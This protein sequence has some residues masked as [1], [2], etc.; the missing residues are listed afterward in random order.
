MSL[1]PFSDCPVN[2]PRRPWSKAI[3]PNWTLALLLLCGM[4]ISPANAQPQDLASDDPEVERQSFRLLPG[5]EVNLFAAEPML[6]NPIHM[7]WD[8]DGR[9]WVV[10]STTY[11]QVEPGEIPDDQIIVLED[12]DSDGKADKRTVFAGGLYVPT[13]LEL[14]DGGVYV[15][16]APDL[17]FLKDTDDDGKADVRR[18]VLSGFGTEDNHHSISAWRWG[19]GGWLYFQEGTFLHAQVETP[20]GLVRLENGGVYQF[21]PQTLELR[22]F[23]DYRASNP[24]GH[25]FDRWG[26]SILID[27]P[28]IFHLSPLTANSRA[29]LDFDELFRA[30]TKH[31]GGEFVSGRHLPEEFR[32]EIWTNAYKTH[33][34][35]RYRLTDADAGYAVRQLE[36]VL[37]SDDPHFRPVELK[38]GPDGAVYIADWYNLLIG[39]MQHEF[40]DPRRDKTHGRIWRITYRDRPLLKKPRLTDAP[41]PELL[42]HLKAPE[43]WTRHQVK[44]VISE[45]DPRTVAAALKQWVATLDADD[46][47]FEHHRLE[48]LWCYQTIDVMEPRLLADVLGSKDGRARAAAVRVIRY[49]HD[50]LQNP[51]GLLAQ[52]A[53]DEHPRV[54]MEAVLSLSYIPHAE[55]MKTALRVLDKPMD[56]F[57][58]HSL[59]LAVDGLERYWLPAFRA[60]DF[61]FENERH[62]TFALSNVRSTD[63]VEPLLSLLNSSTVDFKELD[64]VLDKL[65]DTANSHQLEPVW[66]RLTGITSG[67]LPPE[68]VAKILGL[69]ETAARTR[70]V[71][72]PGNLNRLLR[73]INR[74][75]PAVQIAAVR[76]AGAWRQRNT[77]ARIAALARSEASSPALRRAAVVALAEIGGSSNRDVLLGM[78]GDK[79]PPP[80]RYLGLIGLAVFN[81]D[82]AAEHAGPVLADDPGSADPA[83]VAAAF[84][85][86]KRGAEA[87]ARA[88]TQKAPHPEVAHRITQYLNEIGLQHPELTAALGSASGSDVLEK[89]LLAEDVQALVAD[90]GKYGDAARGERI[91]RRK[92]LACM[93]CHAINGAGPELGPDLASIGSSS[94]ADFLVDAVLR[95]SKAIKDMYHSV[96][97]IT[98][99]GR[100][101]NGILAYK[102][103]REV[104]LRDAARQGVA[105]TIPAAQVDEIVPSETSLMPNGL[106]RN[107]GSRQEFLDLV[108]FLSQLGRPGPY[109]VQ[110]K[111]MIRR[112]RVAYSTLAQTDPDSAPT[113]ESAWTPAYSE[114]NGELPASLLTIGGSD[115]VFARGEIEILQP[116]RIRLAVNANEGLS[117]SI[118]GNSVPLDG[119]T[120]DIEL[121]KG[122]HTITF[123]AD[124]ARRGNVGLSCE[125]QDVPG[126]TAQYQVVVG[127]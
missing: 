118:D 93:S 110:T 97:V 49:W 85:E 99:E 88:L 117:L 40:R 2:S 107:L 106:A 113:E 89:Q 115:L 24:W 82:V 48:A 72:P 67:G 125:L 74:R 90:I 79:Q 1:V 23:A 76:L 17:L 124:V 109:V 75:G 112:W 108:R 52:A 9:L 15:A 47:E 56:R 71:K 22:V 86:R 111:P 92:S 96:T 100:I 42:D 121:P 32:G 13:G 116:G 98:D 80:T 34:I 64:A 36:P 59:K 105:L 77:A 37:Q 28:R 81:I 60:G 29:K 65:A 39:H 122:R 35:D 44:R 3:R 30:G 4:G 68:A 31:C 70:Q 27:N 26:Q 61:V 5:F 33:M 84:V 95:P 103:D 6:T 50:R 53:A 11:P 21:R 16:N 14:G 43:D 91:Y 38:V 94:P 120:C 57:I 18:V 45:R 46:P 127:R 66:N 7:T 20:H 41:L 10:C 55:A 62:R 123:I 114:V 119:K 51:L 69:L 87:L 63:V 78:A 8:A 54:R 73:Y 126:S 104:V 12:A 83:P 58:E 19:P 102:D 101:Y 25:M